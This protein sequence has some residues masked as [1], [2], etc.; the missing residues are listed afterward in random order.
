MTKLT[1]TQLIV[2]SRAAARED[3]S[4]TVPAK[5]NKAAAAKLEAALVSKKL[6]RTLRSKSGMPVW[7]KDE[8]DRPVSLVITR[9]G[10]DAIGVEED[11]TTQTPE[12]KD[13]AFAAKTAAAESASHSVAAERKRRARQQASS[14]AA[15]LSS[16]STTDKTSKQTLVVQMLSAKH[17]TTVDALVAAT[18]WLPHTTRA[19][20]TGLRKRGFR[21]ERDKP[22]GARASTYRIAAA[23]DRS[24]AA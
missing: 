15:A 8:D 6:L 18:G 3:G 7:R 14:D 11:E 4:A 16:G 20:L 12:S 2:L 9:A 23:A 1:D 19:V 22:E 17:G 24:P 10:R 5:I 21:I 13:G